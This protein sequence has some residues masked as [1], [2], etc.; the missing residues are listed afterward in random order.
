MVILPQ[1]K[2]EQRIRIQHQAL[3]LRRD[4]AVQQH[5]VADPDRSDFTPYRRNVSHAFIC[6]GRSAAGGVGTHPRAEFSS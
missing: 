3:A 6:Q 4:S 2:S 5:S 1:W